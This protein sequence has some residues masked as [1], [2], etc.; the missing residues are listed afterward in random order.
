[1]ANVNIRIDDL[2]KQRVENIFSELGLS[3]T[4]GNLLLGEKHELRNRALRVEKIF[5]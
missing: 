4:F 1:M 5:P 3:L 2:L